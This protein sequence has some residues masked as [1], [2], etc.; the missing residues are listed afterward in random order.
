M[1]DVCCTE[2]ASLKEA[3]KT[4]ILQLMKSHP[5][6]TETLTNFT[7][8]VRPSEQEKLHSKLA[9]A[10]TCKRAA[11]YTTYVGNIAHS[12][13]TTQHTNNTKSHSLFWHGVH[14]ILEQAD[15]LCLD[16]ESLGEKKCN[17][18]CLITAEVAKCIH[19]NYVSRTVKS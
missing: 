12:I 16:F 9:N 5:V 2:Q 17:M 14:R 4:H 15:E 7:L 11:L 18:S 8:N 1:A 10:K 13:N 3:S 19:Q 6:A